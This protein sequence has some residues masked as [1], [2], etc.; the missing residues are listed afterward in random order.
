MSAN[1][2]KRKIG[3]KMVPHIWIGAAFWPF[4]FVLGLEDLTRYHFYLALFFL[5]ASAFSIRNGFQ[6]L[7]HGIYSDFVMLALI[8]ILLPVGMAA[9]LIFR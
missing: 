4:L 8:P 2:Y 3:V 9:Y 6:G 5:L 7:R 1:E